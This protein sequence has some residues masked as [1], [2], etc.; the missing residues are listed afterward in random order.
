[1]QCEIPSKYRVVTQIG[2]S[3]NQIIT[4]IHTNCNAR[5]HGKTEEPMYTVICRIRKP[6]SAELP[7]TD[8]IRPPPCRIG[9]HTILQLFRK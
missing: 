6:L 8:T 4:E 9:D 2:H 7:A 3:K 5:K 1:M